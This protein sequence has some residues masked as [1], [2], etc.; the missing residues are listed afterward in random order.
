[1]ATDA[2]LVTLFADISGSTRLY[3]TLG[4]ISAHRIVAECLSVLSGVTLR[5]HGMIWR[6]IGDE[7]LATFPEPDMAVAA[8]V[9]MQEAIRDLGLTGGHFLAIRVGFQHGPV[10]ADGGDVYG[11]A[12]NV[13]ARLAQ[14]AKA[15]EILTTGHTVARMDPHWQSTCRRINWIEVKGKQD[16]LEVCEVVWR[17]ED[18]TVQ[19]TLHT[20]PAVVRGL[21]LIAANTRLELTSTRPLITLGRDDKND[22]M[23]PNAKVSRDHARVELRNG[24]VVLHDHSSNGTFV[25]PRAGTVTFLHRDACELTGHGSFGLGEQPSPDSSARVDFEL[26]GQVLTELSIPP[27]PVHH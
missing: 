19:G 27:R 11:D 15:G 7:V 12:V 21:V 22:L 9:E 10:L 4:D 24:R 13:A 17:P 23:V 26:V 6:T 25:L 5:H 16:P 3:D 8:A 20:H 18:A 1:M 2:I 14:Q